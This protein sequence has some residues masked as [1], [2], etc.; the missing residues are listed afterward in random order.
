MEKLP[1][2]LRYILAVPFGIFCCIIGYYIFW[3]SNA[4]Y[5]SPDS[6]YMT[7]IKYIY[8][9]F[10]N[11]IV[12]IHSINYMLP[13]HHFKFTL[14]ISIIFCGFGFF[15]LGI[16]F[17]TQSITLSSIIGFLL[18]FVAFVGCCY[19]TFYKY[20]DKFNNKSINKNNA[21]NECYCIEC[22][23]KLNNE[24]SFGHNC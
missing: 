24:E 3:F 1:N 19:H 9:N 16:S 2:W 20:V 21:S 14:V 12:M 10:F 13:K 11:V 22:G 18:T 23:A 8:T 5:A 6:L 7:L 4:F 15:G 17:L